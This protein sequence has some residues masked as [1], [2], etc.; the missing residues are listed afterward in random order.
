M[1]KK[2]ILFIC[3][4][5]LCSSFFVTKNNQMYNSEEENIDYTS[6]YSNSIYNDGNSLY[7]P[8][9]YIKSRYNTTYVYMSEA[10]YLSGWEY[11]SQALLNH[12]YN[13]KNS[14]EINGTCGVVACTS[15]TYYLAKTKGFSNIPLNMN[16]IFENYVSHYNIKG[17]E[18]TSSSSYKNAIP[19]IFSNYGYSISATRSTSLY[20]YTKMKEKVK[21]K[22]P[23]IFSTFGTSLY[24]SHSMVVIGYKTYNITYIENNKTKHTTETYYALDEGWGLD[25]AAY[26]LEGNM[27]GTWE[28][29]TIN[30]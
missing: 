17:T 21:E 9:A 14:T 10:Y 7:D 29:T 15:S 28:I 24:E 11:T 19:K 18:G 13:S 5:F 6:Q 2:I 3:G 4:T 16:T 8:Q 30:I 25:K 20:K 1:I 22:M 27:P 23:T 12:V 26:V